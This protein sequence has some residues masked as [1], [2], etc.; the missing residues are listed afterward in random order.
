MRSPAKFKRKV[1]LHFLMKN[2]TF[3]TNPIFKGHGVDL[4][5]VVPSQLEDFQSLQVPKDALRHRRQRVS[6]KVEAF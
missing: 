3:S 2:F 1:N 5:D 6:R 4:N